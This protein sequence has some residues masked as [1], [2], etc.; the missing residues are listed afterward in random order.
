MCTQYVQ[1]Q[2]ASHSR[3]KCILNR[4]TKNNLNSSFTFW[5]RLGSRNSSIEK[6]LPGGMRGGWGEDNVRK[7]GS[8]ILIWLKLCVLQHQLWR[9][10]A[11]RHLSLKSGLLRN[12][13][14]QTYYFINF[15]KGCF[16]SQLFYL[17]KSIY[18]IK[19]ISMKF[20]S[21]F[22]EDPHLD[23]RFITE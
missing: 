9:S 8:G 13:K 23:W 6:H 12:Y 17:L 10:C 11:S 4:A 16:L 7:L 22:L 2:L 21:R 14:K 5:L 3:P 19:G 18:K 15:E 20:Q 1:I